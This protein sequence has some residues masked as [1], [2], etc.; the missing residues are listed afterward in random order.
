MSHVLLN[1]AFADADAQLEES[2][3][4]PFRSQDADSAPPLL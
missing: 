1:G 3:T 4:D 2:A